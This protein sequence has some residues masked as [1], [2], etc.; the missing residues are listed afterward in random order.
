[1]GIAV[2]VRGADKDEGENEPAAQPVERSPPARRIKLKD[3]PESVSRGH[4]ADPGHKGIEREKDEPPG[5][6][7]VG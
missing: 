2:Q 6:F 5:V 3:P 1:M 4:D 7:E